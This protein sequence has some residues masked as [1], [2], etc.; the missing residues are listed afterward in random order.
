MIIYNSP[1]IGDNLSASIKNV[2]SNAQEDITSILFMLLYHELSTLEYYNDNIDLINSTMPNNKE[3]K[4]IEQYKLNETL[5][6]HIDTPF[7]VFTVKRKIIDKNSKYLQLLKSLADNGIVDVLSKKF[8]IFW[9]IKWHGDLTKLI[10][11]LMYDT[12]V[13]SN[14]HVE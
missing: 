3:I 8:R 6:R 7:D 14:L 1:P 2:I 4:L 11:D 10:E 9:N 13:R 12:R 5:L